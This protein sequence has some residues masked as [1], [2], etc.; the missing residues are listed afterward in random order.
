MQVLKAMFSTHQFE[1]TDNLAKSLHTFC[2]A[3]KELSKTIPVMEHSITDAPSSFVSLYMLETIVSLSHKHMSEFYSMGAI[4]DQESGQHMSGDG[5]HMSSLVYSEISQG[6][7]VSVKT[8]RPA[9]NQDNNNDDNNSNK[10]NSNREDDVSKHKALQRHSLEEFSVVLALKDAM[11]CSV[12]PGSVKYSV[13]TRLISDVFPNCDIEG[14]LAHEANV[15]KGMAAKSRQNRNA[16]E[17][18]HESRAASVMQMMQE[19]S[20]PSEGMY[21]HTLPVVKRLVW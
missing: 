17:S 14:L 11:L 13:V 19:E 3:L 9:G 21:V 8:K 12:F 10:N 18:A 5:L 20:H 4:E 15:R 6:T 16:V 7:R 1:N 2:G